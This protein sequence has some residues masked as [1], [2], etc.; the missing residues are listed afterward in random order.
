MSSAEV[1]QKLL[2]EGKV[3][4]EEGTMFGPVEK[5]S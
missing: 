2:H 3:A 1:S 5:D 4:V